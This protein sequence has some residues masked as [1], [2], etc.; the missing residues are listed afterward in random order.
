MC[1]LQM[2]SS[3]SSNESTDSEFYYSNGMSSGA[4]TLVLLGMTWP[5]FVIAV[6]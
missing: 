4:M 1:D 2:S 3:I 5:M 6:G